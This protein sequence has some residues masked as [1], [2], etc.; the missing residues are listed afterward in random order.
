MELTN[1][2]EGVDVQGRVH[3]GTHDDCEVGDWV[4]ARRGGD[5]EIA[6]LWSGLEPCRS[7]LRVQGAGGGGSSASGGVWGEVMVCF[8]G[9]RGRDGVGAGYG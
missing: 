9:D 3:G 8:K 5:N 7:N 1:F 2:Y 4:G 6:G